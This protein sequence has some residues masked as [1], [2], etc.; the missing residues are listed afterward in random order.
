[1]EPPGA[2]HRGRVKLL[3]FLGVPLFS[4]KVL[5]GIL[6]HCPRGRV[7]LPCLVRGK[8]PS[9]PPRG[10]VKPPVSSGDD[11]VDFPGAPPGGG[12]VKPPVSPGGGPVKHP[13]SPG[14]GSVKL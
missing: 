11:R 8:D 7:K 2:P 10:K 14:V 4:L 5:R 13:G 3:A 12:R 6:L 1:M 9:S